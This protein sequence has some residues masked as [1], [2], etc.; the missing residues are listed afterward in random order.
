MVSRLIAETAMGRAWR[1]LRTLGL[2]AL[3]ACWLVGT[4]VWAQDLAEADAL[5]AQV[6]HLYQQGK[7]AEATELAK[8]ALAIRV[9]TL[10]DAHPDTAALHAEVAFL[11]R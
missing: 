3:A 8:R 1:V 11:G 4:P 5:N 10:G 6:V 2:T 9:T 7:Y